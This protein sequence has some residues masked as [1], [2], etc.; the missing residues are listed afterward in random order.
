MPT[1]GQA[2]RGCSSGPVRSCLLT[3]PILPL[4]DSHEGRLDPQAPPE[5]GGLAGPHLGKYSRL[6]V[7]HSART[8]PA[9]KDD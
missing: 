7:A 4:K 6:P 9:E 2:S 8:P 1:E 5:T 3:A